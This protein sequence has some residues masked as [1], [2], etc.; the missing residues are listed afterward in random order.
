MLMNIEKCASK[1]GFV[2]RL[3]IICLNKTKMMNKKS[4]WPIKLSWIPSGAMTMKMRLTKLAR[5]TFPVMMM[6]N[7]NKNEDDL[8][9]LSEL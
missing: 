4:M 7:D 8:T 2:R 1:T 5:L 3:N 9:N 6:K